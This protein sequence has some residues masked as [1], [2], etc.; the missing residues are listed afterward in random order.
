MSDSE[1]YD[2]DEDPTY[3]PELEQV[4]E[5]D[6]EQWR[7]KYHDE[8]VELYTLFMGNG[9]ETFGDAYCQFMNLGTFANLVYK[10]TTPH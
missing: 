2:S 4:D 8:L 10:Y 1:S 5:S 6:R 3:D 7:V 9:R